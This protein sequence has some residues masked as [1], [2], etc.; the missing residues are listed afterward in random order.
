MNDVMLQ[1]VPK[2]YNGT[3]HSNT[4]NELELETTDG[5]VL[6]T[7]SQF[8]QKLFQVLQQY[9]LEVLLV[10]LPSVLICFL[11]TLCFLFCI[12]SLLGFIVIFGVVGSWALTVYMWFQLIGSNENKV[13]TKKVSDLTTE[14][15][16]VDF[17]IT[18][19]L[20]TSLKNMKSFNSNIFDVSYYDV[21]T[22]GTTDIGKQFIVNQRA[23][24]NS[25]LF[26]TIG[27]TV[28][29]FIVTA[30]A[31][32]FR[33]SMDVILKLFEEAGQ[34]IFNVPCILVQP[35]FTFVFVINH[36]IHFFTIC[37][38]IFTIDVPVIDKYGFVSFD[39]DK[40]T[41]H[42]WLFAFHLFSSYWFREFLLA[43]QDIIV[44]GALADWFFKRQQNVCCPKFKFLPCALITP[45]LYVLRYQLGT[46]AYGSFVITAV[47]PIRVL[48]E[49]SKTLVQKSDPSKRSN[50]GCCLWMNKIVSL[51]NTNAYICAGISGSNFF[52]SG[53][54]ALLLYS[55]NPSI[56]SNL[57]GTESIL[58]YLANVAVAVLTAMIA[59][60][61]FRYQ[62]GREASEP[63]YLYLVL[64]VGIISYLFAKS[65]FSAYAQTLNTVFICHAEHEFRFSGEAFLMKENVKLKLSQT[66][67]RHQC[68]NPSAIG[69]TILT[70]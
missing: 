38:Y 31:V 18:E 53:K 34:A 69:A 57:F 15:Y 13:E 12:R 68:L 7:I 54:E 32:L 49:C 23:E 61:Y 43:C 41:P 65:F 52:D 37:A 20:S 30:V 5:D 46:A 50:C 67:L 3:A 39:F 51:V 11:I 56:T 35:V 16:V 63:D 17:L 9:W 19:S 8:M 47:S 2:L 29:C 27:A 66:Q 48:M 64:I 26:W 6:S 58:L 1:V 60:I 44:A 21:F 25:I 24:S 4:T 42:W 36:C 59:F 22:Y 70:K 10:S 33:K 28:I 55:I 62:L 45:T 40:K 14:Q